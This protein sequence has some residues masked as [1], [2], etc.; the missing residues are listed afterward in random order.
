MIPKKNKVYPNVPKELWTMTEKFEREMDLDLREQ[1]VTIIDLMYV[2]PF[3]AIYGA[4]GYCNIKTGD[5]FL[6]KPFW[7]N[8]SKAKKEMTYFHEL[9][10]CALN[11][12]HIRYSKEG[13]DSSNPKDCPMTLMYPSVMHDQCWNNHKDFYFT[14]LRFHYNFAKTETQFKEGE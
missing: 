9:G 2:Q 4:I 6:H 14:T 1:R 5:V 13:I 8:A 12:R 3:L 7:D 11:L 10:H